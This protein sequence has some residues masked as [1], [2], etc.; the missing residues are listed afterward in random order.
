M[1]FHLPL[2][3]EEE[4]GHSLLPHCC[5]GDTYYNNN[6]IIPSVIPQVGSEDGHVYA[7]FSLPCEGRETPTAYK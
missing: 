4:G 3:I 5:T 1:V 2:G 6:N 7:A